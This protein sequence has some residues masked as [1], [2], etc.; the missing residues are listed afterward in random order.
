MGNLGMPLCRLSRGIREP[1]SPAAAQ[2]KCGRRVLNRVLRSALLLW[3]L[4]L[5]LLAAPGAGQAEVTFY[6]DPVAFT[7]A[8]ATVRVE[9]FERF[10]QANTNLPSFSRNGNSYEPVGSSTHVFVATKSNLFFDVPPSQRTTVLTGSGLE[11]FRVSFGAPQRAV[12][13]DS[14]LNDLPA[15]VQ[16]FGA[17]GKLLAQR[18]HAH[19]STVT[20]FLGMVATEPITAIRWTADP[21]SDDGNNT[22]IET[23]APRGPHG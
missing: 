2:S 8:S 4:P 3:G 1:M 15:R 22:G 7:A 9:D 23:S 5:F 20:G 21:L 18:T 19:A 16:V 12:G 6:T 11:D 17:G 13:F 14:Y 10:P